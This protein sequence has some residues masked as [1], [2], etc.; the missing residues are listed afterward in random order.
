MKTIELTKS[1]GLRGEVTPPPDKSISHR[2]IMFASMAKGKSV[3]RNFLRAEDPLSTIKAFRML[4]IQITDSAIGE[5]TIEGKGLNGFTEPFDVI[6][7]GNSGT[8]IRLIS[9]LLAGN[10]IPLNPD[11]GR[12]TET[13]AHGESDQSSQTDGGTNSAR[14]GNRYPPSSY[15]RHGIE[16]YRLDDAHCI[17]TGEILHN[18]GRT[19]CR[20]DDDDH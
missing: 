17:S 19:V 20:R 1:K 8:T 11:R 18:I 15:N 3:V 2:S 5:V 4:G 9:G 6:D 7:C 14:G 13:E 16:S 10:R 12:F